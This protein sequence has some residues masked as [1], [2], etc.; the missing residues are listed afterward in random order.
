MLNNPLINRYGKII[1][2]LNMFQDT[3]KIIIK[4]KK[5]IMGKPII[6]SI[7]MLIGKSKN[8][9]MYFLFF[10]V[11]KNKIEYMARRKMPF[12]LNQFIISIFILL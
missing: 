3:T 9:I 7:F 1:K 2:N 12:S 5:I 6:Q 11:K 10:A 8:S 4:Y